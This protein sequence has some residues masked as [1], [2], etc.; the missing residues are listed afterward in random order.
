[1]HEVSELF[2]GLDHLYG[3]KVDAAKH[4]PPFFRGTDKGL[5][6]RL[7]IEFDGEVDDMTAFHQTIGRR[8][9]P[10][11]CDVDAYRGASPDNLVISNLKA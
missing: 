4:D 1:M 10:T 9:G 7:A 11:A 5:Q 2:D 3:T 6:R 8:I